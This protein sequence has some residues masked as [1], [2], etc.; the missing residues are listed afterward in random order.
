M[1]L[2]WKCF[3]PQELKAGDRDQNRGAATSWESRRIATIMGAME[4]GN[5]QFWEGNKVTGS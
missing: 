5:Q 3:I 2:V 4:K 1:Y